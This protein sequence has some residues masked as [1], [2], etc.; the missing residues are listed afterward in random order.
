MSIIVI[1]RDAT[2]EELQA[3]AKE[4]QPPK[5]PKPRTPR[6]WEVYWAKREPTIPYDP[7][8]PITLEELKAFRESKGWFQK[9]LAKRTGYSPETIKHMERGSYK[10]PPMLSSM[11]HLMKEVDE[12]KAEIERLKASQEPA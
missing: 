1:P 11:I 8:P 10:I 3:K 2:E 4:L 5:E 6:G 12:L 9:H 7:P